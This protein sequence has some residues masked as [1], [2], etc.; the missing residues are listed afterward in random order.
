MIDAD[1]GGGSQEEREWRVGVGVGG[2]GG[3][4]RL[5]RTQTALFYGESRSRE[6]QVG[7]SV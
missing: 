3:M 6:Y 5:W 4:I 7:I 2:L 1:T